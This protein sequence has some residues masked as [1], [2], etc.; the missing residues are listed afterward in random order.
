M[1]I[2]NVSEIK[3]EKFIKTGIKWQHIEM[4]SNTRTHTHT[5]THMLTRKT[6]QVK[7]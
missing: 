7:T 5:H 4:K 6:K 1:K 2:R 3:T